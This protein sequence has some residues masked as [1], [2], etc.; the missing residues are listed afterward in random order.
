MKSEPRPWLEWLTL[1]AFCGFLFFF[2]LSAFGLLGADEPRYAQVAR[3]MLARH[4]W[5]TPVLYGRP[6]L[7]K[8]I[9]YYWEAMLAYIIFGVKDWVAR[10]PSAASATVMVAVVYFFYRRFRTGFELDAAL[11]V[12]S[13]AAVIGFAHAASTDMP[14][15]A[16]FVIAML[17]WLGWYST[18]ERW[19]LLVFYGFLG[20]ATL[21]KGPVAVALALLIIFFFALAQRDFLP[22]RRTLWIPGIL[23]FVVVAL[24]WYVLVQLRNPDFFS[25]FIVRQNFA[26]F[27]TNLYRHKQP[28]WYFIPVLLLSLVPWT[29]FAGGGFYDTIRR[30]KRQG[31]ALWQS[32]DGWDVF[33]VIWTVVIVVFFSISQSKLP[34]YIL[35]AVPAC[36]LVMVDYLQRK[37]SA[38]S[39]PKAAW[40][41]LHAAL[42][43]SL[44]APALLSPYLLDHRSPPAQGIWIAVV[45]AVVVWIALVASLLSRGMRSLRF[46]TLVP[47]ILALAILIRWGGPVLDRT[48]SARPIAAEL[49][50]MQSK[51]MPLATFGVTRET[52]Y[53]LAFYRNTV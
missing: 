38:L 22:V 32:E 29:I 3:E 11:M 9:L 23:L 30:W 6:W 52:L 46:V 31:R 42:S 37:S 17:G 16:T 34:G 53:G 39:R 45:V 8:P 12:A 48:Q 13:T 19:G 47:V 7:E 51:P 25:E 50:A 43:A 36:T 41:I 10:L 20:L 1:A 27:A 24:P 21:A 14:L 35:P 44:L 4:D 28:F 18:G 40:L 2:G 33:F 49:A 15:A 26:R 5:V